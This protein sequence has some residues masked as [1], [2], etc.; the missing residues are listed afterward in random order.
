[1]R[2]RKRMSTFSVIL[3]DTFLFSPTIPLGLFKQQSLVVSTI[4]VAELTCCSKGLGITSP[5]SNTF[6]P[7]MGSR[8]TL[9]HYGV[10]LG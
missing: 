1:M 7:L 4:K 3:S 5:C 2:T 8:V 10:T 6:L 9:G